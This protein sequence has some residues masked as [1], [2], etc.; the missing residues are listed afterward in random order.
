M[1]NLYF[2]LDYASNY[3]DNADLVYN[4]LKIFIKIIKNKELVK[5]GNCLFENIMTDELFLKILGN[6]KNNIF[7]LTNLF[8]FSTLY[9][10]MMNGNHPEKLNVKKKIII[11]IIL[12]LLLDL[13]FYLFLLV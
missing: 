5:V 1:N 2:L 12:I 13:L 7:I 8:Y 4:F 11:I 6:F 10:N 3:Y 9:F